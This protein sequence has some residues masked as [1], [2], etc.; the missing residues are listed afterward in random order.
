MLV[1]E[2]ISTATWKGKLAFY[3]YV[4]WNK[5]SFPCY[6]QYILYFI[7]AG[8]IFLFIIRIIIFSI[9]CSEE[10]LHVISLS[11]KNCAIFIFTAPEILQQY[12]GYSISLIQVNQI[13]KYYK[14][15]IRKTR[16]FKKLSPS[17]KVL[18]IFLPVFSSSHNQK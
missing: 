11:V 3:K 2:G 5:Y 12:L 4:L 13:T 6:L 15:H 9:V 7:S 10:N 18:K 14:I 17:F 16:I 8:N 1:R